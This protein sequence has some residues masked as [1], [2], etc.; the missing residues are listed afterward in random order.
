MKHLTRRQIILMAEEAGIT[1]HAA[2]VRLVRL[3]LCADRPQ[4]I[5]SLLSQPYPVDQD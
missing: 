5:K 4:A 2:A 1:D 3:T